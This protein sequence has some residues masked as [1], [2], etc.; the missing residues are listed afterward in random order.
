MQIDNYLI[1]P[2]KLFLL[3]N[4]QAH[5]NVKVCS[6]VK[7]IKYIYKYIFKGNNQ[8]TI[9]LQKKNDE[10]ARYLSSHYIGPI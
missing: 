6:F 1:V 9:Q 3:Q 5:I 7:G 4:Y 10:I 2:Y 8:M